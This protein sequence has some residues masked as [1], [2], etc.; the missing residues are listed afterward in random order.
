MDDPQ[1][2]LAWRGL[3]ATRSLLKRLL[4]S[5]SRALSN[6]ISCVQAGDDIGARENLAKCRLLEDIIEDISGEKAPD[7][8]GET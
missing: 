8:F 3:K 4:D 6:V 1:D 7:C 5:R 2:L